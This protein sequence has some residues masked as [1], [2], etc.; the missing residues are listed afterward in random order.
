[1]VDDGFDD[2]SLFDGGKDDGGRMEEREEALCRTRR[3]VNGRTE[4]VNRKGDNR[5]NEWG[6]EKIKVNWGQAAGFG[7]R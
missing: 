7:I 4:G 5:M 1:M 3:A 2:G 6:A